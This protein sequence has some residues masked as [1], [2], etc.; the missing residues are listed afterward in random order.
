MCLKFFGIVL[1]SVIVTSECSKILLIHPSFSRSHV[2]PLQALAKILSQ[3]G[4]EITFV[5][6]FP[7]DKT[8][9]N[10][11]DIKVESSKEDKELFDEIGKTMSDRKSPFK[12]VSIASKATY[13]IGV[14]TLQSERIKHLMDNEN[15]DLVIIGYFLNE[16][17]LGLADHFKCP[18][19]LFF[20]GSFFSTLN[21][22]IGN[23]LLPEAI[24]HPII[25]GKELTFL[26][27]VF[28][29]VLNA[30]DIF[31]TNFYFSP[32]SKDIYK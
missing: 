15:F 17:L 18:S 3:K 8:I 20:S 6:L 27:R 25:N 9:E 29:L 16:F 10:Y 19:I 4:H 5:S 2:I 1:I 7:F 11:R 12:L 13:K 28:N 32:Q 24:P 14:K 21:R 26:M 30:A 31:F 22:I 23:P